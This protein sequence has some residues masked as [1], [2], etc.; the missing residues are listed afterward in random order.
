MSRLASSFRR[1]LR[2]VTR[3]TRLALVAAGGCLIRPA[4]AAEAARGAPEIYAVVVGWN[5]GNASVPPLRFADDDAVRFARFFAGLGPPG[6]K[7]TW[8]LT[9]PDA[10]TQATLARAELPTPKAAA[11]TREA[12]LGALSDLAS[13]LRRRPAQGPRILY[14]VY[15]G[16]GLRGRVLLKA[17]AGTEAALSGTELRAALAEVA[18]A[19]P[20]LRIFA[21]LDACRS[22]SLFADRGDEGPDLG[23][24]IGALEERAA[25]LSIGV[26]TAARNGRPAGEVKR[27]EAGY[28]SHVL[29]SGLAG[30]ADADGDD[31]VTFGELAAFVAFHTERLTG[32][33]P[34]FDPPGGD[35]GA[36]AIDHRGRSARVLLP[37]AGSGRYLIG[38][39]GGLPIFVEA[40]KAAGRTLR[41]ALPPG[42][43][44]AR[45]DGDGGGEAAFELGPDAPADLA[46]VTWSAR[47]AT[48]RGST[49]AAAGNEASENGADSTDAAAEFSAPFSSEAVAALSAGFHAGREPTGRLAGRHALHLAL[50]LAPAP[51]GLG[52]TELGGAVGYRRRLGSF[53]VGGLGRFVTSTHTTDRER[54]EL[55]CLALGALVGRT[56]H[57]GRSLAV[58]A[59]AAAGWSA[60]LRSAPSGTSGDLASPFA[61]LGLRLDVPLAEG[62]F[63]SIAGRLAG[64]LV[65]V[66]GAWD[67]T[68]GPALDLGMGAQF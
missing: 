54:Y 18:A 25:A 28:F 59:F 7:R 53:H 21:F 5:G 26:L 47:P 50:A 11:P 31:V 43:Y 68:G 20:G 62:W 27:L 58:E 64:A 60:V 2:W 33:Q 55:R 34:W 45:R 40:W 44:L 63:L 6:G 14:F 13:D 49:G 38:A 8:L 10:A 65:D 15:A 51:L 17:T 61:E 37:A 41:L 3:L 4:T 39:P 29:T 66:D 32:Q 35:L 30:V 36:S 56:L 22:Q 16:H 19:A 42:R 23:A 57:A 48:A 46:A 24:A 52:G 67:A 1:P 12:V 9:E